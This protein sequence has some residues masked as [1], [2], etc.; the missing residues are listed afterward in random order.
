M[1]IEDYNGIYISTYEGLG[2]V[3]TI[4]HSESLE[5]ARD[6]CHMYERYIESLT[7]EKFIEW[8]EYVE[9]NK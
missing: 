7:A 6:M 9:Q 8:E 4:G 2:V 5:G 1:V 3:K